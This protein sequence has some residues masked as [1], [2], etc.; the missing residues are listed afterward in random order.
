MSSLLF[1]SLPPAPAS[2]DRPRNALSRAVGSALFV[3]A[4]I[5]ALASYD[6]LATIE[7]G[8]LARA[9]E[10]EIQEKTPRSSRAAWSARAR[11]AERGS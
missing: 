11:P 9:S 1:P 5:A 8:L 3:V 10:L 6:T 4:A 2:L 7:T